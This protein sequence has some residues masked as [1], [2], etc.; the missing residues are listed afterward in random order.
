MCAGLIVVTCALGWLAD[1]Q[2]TGARQDWSAYSISLLSGVLPWL[3]IGE[4]LLL[5]GI[6][7]GVRLPWFS[8]A[9][10]ASVLL[11]FTLLAVNQL[12]NIRKHNQWKQY[13]YVERNY[14]V[15]DLITKA[16]F[17][18]ILIVGLRG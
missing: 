15:I 3:V 10:A 8:Y 14:I 9:L 4:V 11:G 13:S 17:A 1:R 16:A 2:N 18:T 6:Y 5:T 7:G 12:L